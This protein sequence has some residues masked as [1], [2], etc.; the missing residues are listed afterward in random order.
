MAATFLGR[1]CIS[2]GI[3]L[4]SEEQLAIVSNYMKFNRRIGHLILNGK[5]RIYGNKIDNY[6]KAKGCQAIVREDAKIGETLVVCHSF[7]LDGK[8]AVL[9]I[10]LKGYT[11]VEEEITD[12]IESHCSP[13]SVKIEFSKSWSGAVFHLIKKSKSL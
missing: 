11:I 5:S 8:A 9:E 7:D 4:L 6:R 1:L 13:N 10:D 12:E 3:D 2:G